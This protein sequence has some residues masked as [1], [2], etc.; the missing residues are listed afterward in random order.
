MLTQ[1]TREAGVER[2]WLVQTRLEHVQVDVTTQHDLPVPT[3]ILQHLS[4][5]KNDSQTTKVLMDS[6][7]IDPSLKDDQGLWQTMRGARM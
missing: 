6:P 4:A 1:R 2:A 7:L 3:F 5:K